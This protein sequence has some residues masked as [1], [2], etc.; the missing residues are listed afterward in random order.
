M[1]GWSL[2]AVVCCW[3]LFQSGC[4]AEEPLSDEAADVHTWMPLQVG[5]VA[6]EAQLAITTPEMQRGL[7]HRDSLPENG[8]MLFLYASARRVSFWMANTRIPLDIGYFNSAGE[9][10]EIHRLTPFDTDPVPSHSGAVRFALEM[11]RGWFAS[12]GVR[13]GARLDL[14]L[15]RE[16]I[17]RRGVDPQVY[18]LP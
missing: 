17:R 9:L 10:L 7:M 11:N 15:L 16:A 12:N 13:P 1:R 3:V 4:R 18:G 14:D 2:I 8:G 5:G 6:I